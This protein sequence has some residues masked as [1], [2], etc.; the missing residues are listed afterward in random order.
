[1]FKKYEIRVDQ[2][3]PLIWE[4]TL[5]KGMYTAPL[6][7]P[8]KHTLLVKA[9]NDST[10][11]NGYT[12]FSI[13]AL[14]LPILLHYTAVNHISQQPIVVYGTADAGNHILVNFTQ[15]NVNVYSEDIQVDQQGRFLFIIDKKIPPGAY[16]M[17][18]SAYNETG[19]SSEPTSPVT[20][21]VK[22]YPYFDLGIMVITLPILLIIFTVLLVT[23]IVLAVIYY[24]KFQATLNKVYFINP[25]FESHRI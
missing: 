1:M 16:T 9:I 20:I 13:E 19:A 15:G 18:L 14:P 17:S 7:P 4:D 10:E 6:L 24:L 3:E 23:A 12:D 2:G 25:I 5:G 21:K 8:G 22:R 11:I